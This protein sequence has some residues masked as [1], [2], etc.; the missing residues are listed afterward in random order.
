MGWGSAGFG[1]FQGI[2]G[3]GILEFGVYVDVHDVLE[4]AG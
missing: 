3:C 4:V 2:W 1:G